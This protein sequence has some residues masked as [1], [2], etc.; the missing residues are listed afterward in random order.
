MRSQGAAAAGEDAAYAN[1]DQGG[2]TW[3]LLG[4]TAAGAET[5]ERDLSFFFPDGIWLPADHRKNPAGCA[6]RTGPAKACYRLADPEGAVYVYKE[7]KDGRTCIVWRGHPLCGDGFTVT[8]ALTPTPEGD[9]WSY[10]FSYVGNE[11]GLGVRLIEL[12]MRQWCIVPC[13]P[14]HC[15]AYERSPLTFFE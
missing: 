5:E 4:C 13:S 11:S 8:A 6:V 7:E 14:P 2:K 1:C 12:L 9:G 15:M 3:R 10:A